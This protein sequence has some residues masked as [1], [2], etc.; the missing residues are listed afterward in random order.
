MPDPLVDP[1]A[2]T[3]HPTRAETDIVAD[4]ANHEAQAI[5]SG[6]TFPAQV[7]P[8]SLN[9]ADAVTPQ[10]S[11]R[12]SSDP[13]TK[14]R[15]HSSSST[16]TAAEPKKKH[17]SFGR[18]KKDE[19]DKK[20][21]EKEDEANKV[22]AVGIFQL[23]RFSKPQEIIFNIIGLVLAAASGATQPLMT[24]IFGRLTND[25]TNYGIIVGEI[26]SGG[27]TPERAALLQE[28]KDALK[29]QAGHNALYL[30]ALGL[31]MFV[32]TWAYMFIWN[33]TGELNAKRVRERYLRATLRQEVRAIGRPS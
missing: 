20:S 12:E 33:T 29:T 22:P 21:K 9:P 6:V 24:L 13:P 19:E 32:T 8:M 18:K 26:T 25:F 30:M 7:G 17:F 28:A 23:Y 14:V 16:S 5:P 27:V 10:T 15:S 3:A 4:A 1:P 11:S 31:G 2:S